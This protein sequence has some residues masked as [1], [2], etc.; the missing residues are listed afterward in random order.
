MQPETQAGAPVGTASEFDDS[1]PPHLREA[2]R[3]CRILVV[4]DDALVRARLA[5]LLRAS[6]FD[7]ESAGSG[8]DATAAAVSSVITIAL[9]AQMGSKYD[10]H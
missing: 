6:Q 4:D 7:V 9:D 3:R 5:T 10:I 8:E 1:T 2:R